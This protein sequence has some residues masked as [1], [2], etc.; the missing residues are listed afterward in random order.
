MLNYRSSPFTF[1][2][3]IKTILGGFV[4]FAPSAFS[5]IPAKKNPI[6]CESEVYNSH[7]Y[8]LVTSPQASLEIYNDD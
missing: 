6:G 3:T 2:I 4:S 8:I 1:P 7:F 5:G